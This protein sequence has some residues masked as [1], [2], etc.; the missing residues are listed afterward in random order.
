MRPARR[1]S[2]NPHAEAEQFR[3]RAALGFV[4]VAVALLGL[5]GWY[6]KLQVVDHTEYATLSEANRIKPKPVVPGRG[7][8]FDRKG[9]LLAENVPAFRLEVMPEKAGDPKKLVAELGKIFVLTPEDIE[10]FEA[11][12]KATRGFRPIAL[13]LRVSEEEMARF[14]VDR[15]RFPGVEL[16]PYLTRRYPYGDLFAHI[17]GYVS[18]IDDKDLETLGEGNAALTHIGKTGLERYYEETLR[19]KIGYEQVET[20]VEGRALRTVGRVP[21]QAGLDLRLSVDANLQL[22]MVQ[23]FGDLEGS[24][25]ALDPRTGEVLAMVSLPSY[26][27]NLFVNGISHADF[28]ALNSNPSRPQFNRLVLGGVAPGST[29]KPLT[30]LAGM[31]SGLRKPEDRVLSTGMFRLPGMTGRGWG[32]SH[33]GGHGWTD[34]RKSIYESVNTYYYRL[35]LD[36]GVQRYDEYM[37]RYGF[38]QK[39]GIDLMGEIEGIVPSPESKRKY[40]KERWYPGDLVNSAIGQGL[41]KATLLQLARGT[42]AIADGGL[43]RRPH[44]A[45]EQRAGFDAPWQPLPQPAPL[46]I[47]DRADHVRVVQE[48]ME[49]TVAI[50]TAA[51]VFRGSAYRSAGKT[52]TAQVVN[53]S[54]VA[55]NPKSLPLWKR[56]RALYVGYAP[57]ENPTIAVAVA[58]EGGGYGASTA[59]PIARKVFDAWLLGKMPDVPEVP[60]SE[61]PIAGALSPSPDG[62]GVGAR[63]RGETSAGAGVEPASPASESANAEQ[64]AAPRVNRTLTPTPLPPGE[65]LKPKPQERSP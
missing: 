60:G 4:M 47:S 17:V 59:A 2:K 31:D 58:V 38:G 53:R 5:A 55:V 24:A 63:V 46:R 25:V 34:A 62:R 29:V 50:G 28:N 15:W 8:I 10:R 19:G 3:R 49:M 6:F 48:G 30:A 44:L 13:K 57:A 22:A 61:K 65:G 32:D 35:A 27:P 39:T 36:M 54:T 40:A 9:R 11:T 20:N 64:S 51:S 7:T 21:A 33:R 42:A 52:G 14:A 43:M 56:H 1:P 18:R 16:E 23:A 12:R 26:D 45:A 37:A 41:W